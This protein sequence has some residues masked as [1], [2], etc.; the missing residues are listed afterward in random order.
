MER[1]IDET[2]IVAER[3]SNGE[4][5]LTGEPRDWIVVEIPP[6]HES[7]WIGFPLYNY[8]VDGWSVVPD[9]QD[10]VNTT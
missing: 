3:Q 10:D 5:D 1:R 2:G 6:D 4:V 9:S 8:E 7:V